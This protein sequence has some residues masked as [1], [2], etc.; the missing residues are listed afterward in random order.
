MNTK[1]I[2]CENHDYDA[3]YMTVLQQKMLAKAGCVVP[4]IE[5]DK[6]TKICTD[7]EN[8]TI[9]ENVYTNMK[10][11]NLIE[12]NDDPAPCEY[13]VTTLDVLKSKV[14]TVV[15]V[16]KIE[17]NLRPVARLV[18]QVDGYTFLSFMAEVGGYM[19]LFLGM[20]VYQL[21]EFIGFCMDKMDKPP[22]NVT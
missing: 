7:E 5:R 3:T 22:K 8:A 15:D 4:W 17:I 16:K 13:I 19:G 2:H 6:E 20:S 9:A 1:E 12:N 21:A 11:I 14:V 10:K 18:E